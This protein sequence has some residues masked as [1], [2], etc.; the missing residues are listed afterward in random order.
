MGGRE[1]LAFHGEEFAGHNLG[2]HVEDAERSGLSTLGAL[3]VVAEHFGRPNLGVEDDVVL[4]HEVV[5][6][7]L[8]IIPPLAPCFGVAGATCPLD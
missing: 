6:Q 2:R 7:G 1:F 3:T 5:G 8:G 4:A